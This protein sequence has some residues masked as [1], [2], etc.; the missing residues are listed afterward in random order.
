MKVIVIVSQKQGCLKKP[1]FQDWSRW[2]LLVKA[3]NGMNCTGNVGPMTNLKE[4]RGKSLSRGP[5]TPGEAFTVW[6][7]LPMKTKSGSPSG[8]RSIWGGYMG[9]KTAFLPGEIC[10]YA[11]GSPRQ[12]LY[13]PKGQ[14]RFEPIEVSRG[15]SS[16]IGNKCVKGRT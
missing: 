16:A 9:R 3:G 5:R 14:G 4:A 6:T 8:C 2:C 15:H 13:K 7:S 1:Q 11:R 10:W 12:D